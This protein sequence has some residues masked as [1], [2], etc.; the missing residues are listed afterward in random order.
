LAFACRQLQVS[1][2]RAC[3]LMGMDC[4][5]YRYERRADRNAE[6]REALVSLARQKPRHG[7]RPVHVLLTRRDHP[8]SLM[9]IYR[10]YRAE[11]LAVRRPKWKRL[12]RVAVASHLV[13]R[14][15]DGH[16]ILPATPLARSRL[17][18]VLAVVDAFT[19]ENIS[20]EV[21]TSL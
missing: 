20:L 3:K 7:Y 15:Q 17:I 16:W 14:N 21:D 8:A 6:L 18:R 5:S 19:E 2:R 9:R 1:D 11:G 12:S 10:L 4:G 13:R